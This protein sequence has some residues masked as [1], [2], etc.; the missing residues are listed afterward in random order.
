MPTPSASP[1]VPRAAAL[2]AVRGLAILLMV[3]SGR[4]PFGVLPDWMYH[5]QVPP[6]GH[7]FD[8]TLPGITWVDLVF[9]FFLFSMGAAIPLALSRRLRAGTPFRSMAGGILARGLLLAAFAIYVMHIRPWAMEDPPGTPVLL[10]CLAGFLL[11]F[12]MYMRF[13]GSWKKETRW[14]LRA[15]GWVGA[16]VLMALFRAK[17]GT[18]F[19]LERSDIIILVLSNVSVTGAFLWLFTRENLLLRLGVLP[20]VLALR[21]AAH[22]PGWVQWFWGSSPLPW[23]FRIPFQQYLFL[24]IPG[25]VVGDL[26][27]RWMEEVPKSAAVSAWSRGRA[28]LYGLLA[29]GANV[30]LV[31]GLKGRWVEWTSVAAATLFGLL[32]FLTRNPVTPTEEFLRRLTGWAAASMLLG[33]LFE[34]YEGGIKKDHPTMSYYFVTG[35]LAMLTLGAFTVLIDLFGKGRAAALL[36][37]AGRNPLVAYAGVNSLVPPVLGLVG[38]DGLIARLTPTPWL[39]ALRG[40][41]MTWLV[42]LAASFTARRGWLLKT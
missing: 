31:V 22:E 42:A 17:D 13:P 4:I 38:L 30:L 28:A 8:P 20:I 32:W 12:P 37:G 33:L 24:V 26:I 40:A 41:F 29:A 25:T 16:A 27:L 23:L 10:Y 35:S 19:S 15:A 36:V 14:V 2:D 1:P 9:P 39:G 5:A 34:P 6:P 11:L 7:R 18:G 3:F 21:L